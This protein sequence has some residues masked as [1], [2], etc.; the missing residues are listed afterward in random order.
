MRQRYLQPSP[1]ERY[2]LR[3]AVLQ[4]LLPFIYRLFAFYR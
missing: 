1:H 4:H 3:Y 2:Y